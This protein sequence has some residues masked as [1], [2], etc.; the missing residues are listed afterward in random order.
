MS[1]EASGLKDARQKQEREGKSGGYY[2]YR[3]SRDE[4]VA[5]AVT[6]LKQDL[7]KFSQPKPKSK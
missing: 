2:A 3:S 1:A 7:K 6:Q 4:I 5:S